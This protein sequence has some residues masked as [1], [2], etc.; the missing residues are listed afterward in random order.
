MKPLTKCKLPRGMTL[1]CVFSLSGMFPSFAHEFWVDPV[2][3]GETFSAELRVGQNLSGASYPYFSNTIKNMTHWAPAG[4]VAIIAREGDRPAISNLSVTEP[5][6]HRVTVQ[7]NP[8][9][10][11]FDNMTEFEDYLRDEGQEHILDIH[12]A[13]ELPEIE[14]AEAYIRNAKSL[15]Q[16]GPIDVSQTDQTTDLPF[17]LTIQ[18]NPFAG[19][20]TAFDVHLT[21]NGERVSG[22]QIAVYYVA[23]NGTAPEDTRRTLLRTDKDGRVSVD[24]SGPGEYLL[25]AVRMSPV[26]GP[27]SVVW[28]SYWASLTFRITK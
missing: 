10:I 18:G 22:A 3:S 25:N 2:Q 12:Q 11:V 24:L 5:G 23:L 9:Y 7:T 15:T 28:E 16:V 1:A 6:L 17:E 27:G 13:R 19:G 14:I 26:E 4:E 8:A 20:V 21:W